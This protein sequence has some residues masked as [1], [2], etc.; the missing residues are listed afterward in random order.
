VTD[1]SMP[2]LDGMSLARWLW[3][4]CPTDPPIL[5]TAQKLD[6]PDLLAFRRTFTEV[7]FKPVEVERFL[8]MIDR[9]MLQNG[10]SPHT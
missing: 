3:C 1:L 10:F 7:V 5:R 8:N 4:S 2:N 6:G 9:L